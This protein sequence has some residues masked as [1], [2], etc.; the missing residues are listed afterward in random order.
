[1]RKK[2]MIIYWLF[3]VCKHEYFC[4]M[5]CRKWF[6]QYNLSSLKVHKNKE[7]ILGVCDNIYD[8]YK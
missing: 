4:F 2:N 1:M 7:E 5:W 3:G 8:Q 6:C